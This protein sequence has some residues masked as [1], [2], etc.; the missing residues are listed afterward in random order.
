[1]PAISLRGYPC[2]P[3][4][5]QTRRDPR[6][7]R[8][9][10]HAHRRRQRSPVGRVPLRSRPRRRAMISAARNA[11]FYADYQRGELDIAPTWLRARAPGGRIAPAGHGHRCSEAFGA[12]ASA[13][14]AAPG[15]RR[16][17]RA[18]HRRPGPPA[19]DHHRHQR[20][21]HPP[22]ARPS[23][24]SRPARLCVELADGVFTGEATGTLTYRE[25]KV[26]RLREW[27]ER[28]KRSAR[29]RLV[30]QRLAQRP[31]PAGAGR[32]PG[33]WWTRMRLARWAPSAAGRA[34]QPARLSPGPRQG[35][36]AAQ[37]SSA[38]CAW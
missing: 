11:R 18:S 22:I 2:I 38:Q 5:G 24:G 35:L 7:L 12:N 20:V 25:G 37:L 17:D 16:A 21:R 32:Q 8:S 6:H 4:P 13:D 29:R 33:G 30:L 1:L 10:Q 34:D 23:W 28:G 31:A 14:H 36:R 9:R 15:R 3:M 27:L 19:A 26:Q